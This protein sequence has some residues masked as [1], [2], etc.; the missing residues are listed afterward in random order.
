MLRDIASPLISQYILTVCGKALA[1]SDLSEDIKFMT[2][3]WNH[4]CILG[5]DQSYYIVL[6]R[7]AN[8]V[9]IGRLANLQTCLL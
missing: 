7:I 2:S 5:K 8:G 4:G 1:S 9:V 3:S 6:S